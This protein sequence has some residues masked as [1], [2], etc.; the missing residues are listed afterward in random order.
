[1]Y[2]EDRIPN[3]ALPVWRRAINFMCGIDNSDK[4]KSDFEQ[5]V[6]KIS[7]EDEAKNAAESL[8][9][10]PSWKRFHFFSLFLISPV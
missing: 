2:I 9:E 8:E 10:E 1:M 4:S 6:P 5:T 7:K 3:E